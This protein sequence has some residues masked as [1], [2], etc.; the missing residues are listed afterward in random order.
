MKTCTIV[1]AH[2]RKGNQVSKHV[3]C[4][5]S[6]QDVFKKLE[7]DNKY[8]LPKVPTE[9]VFKNGIEILPREESQKTN[10][11]WDDD[12]Y[13]NLPKERINI[14]DI[15]PTQKN[16]NIDNLKAVKDT[17]IDTGAFLH[18]YKGKY[19]VLDGHHR[20][21]MN[22]LNGNEIIKGYVFRE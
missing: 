19:Y 15:I 1:K 2:V 12:S 9:K 6:K 5:K 21:A 13:K 3:R 18:F 4:T 20:I 14:K 11:Y 10:K 17:T 8:T 7:E 22:I 16:L